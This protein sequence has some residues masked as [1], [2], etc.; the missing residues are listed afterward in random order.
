MSAVRTRQEIEN[1]ENFMHI[2]RTQGTPEAVA[3]RLIQTRDILAHQEIDEEKVK[4]N[5]ANFMRIQGTPESV[6]QR[7]MD[8][9][10]NN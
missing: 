6:A 10:S 7:I 2:M 1:E 5:E 9:S 4:E 8:L 3:Q